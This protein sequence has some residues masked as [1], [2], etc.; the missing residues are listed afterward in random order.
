VLNFDRSTVKYTLQNTQNDRH[1]WLSD[2]SIVHQIR[3][4]SGVY[5]DPAGELTALPR[6]PIA[7]LR[8][9]NSKGRGGKGK[10][11]DRGGN[12]GGRERR[13]TEEKG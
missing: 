11:K 4:R 13:G 3:F 10:G 8:R 7:G 5:P 2:S 12:G 1:Q 9:P 6:L